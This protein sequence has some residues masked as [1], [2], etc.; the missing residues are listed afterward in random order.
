MLRVEMFAAKHAINFL[1]L[2]N[3][4]TSLFTVYQTII[5]SNAVCIHPALAQHP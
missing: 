4:S 2:P 1:N 3:F 5:H